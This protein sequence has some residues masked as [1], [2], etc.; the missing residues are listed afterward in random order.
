MAVVAA[1]SQVAAVPSMD[2]GRGSLLGL[3]DHSTLDGPAG[4]R[5]HKRRT[6]RL[7]DRAGSRLG[8]GA[9]RNLVDEGARSLMGRRRTGVLVGDNL[10]GGNF[11]GGRSWAGVGSRCWVGRGDIGC[12]GLTCRRVVGGKR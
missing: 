7:A 3:V 5:Y 9:R 8:R 2:L 6:G 10:A 1:H 12:K 4:S 11:V